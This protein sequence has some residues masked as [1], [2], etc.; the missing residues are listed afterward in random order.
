M[1]NWFLITEGKE[2]GPVQPGRLR[3]LVA[4]G[5][6]RPNDL[7]RRDDMSKPCRADQIKGLFP[8]SAQSAM[9]AQLPEVR[10]ARQDATV[11]VQPESA[12]IDSM[13]SSS[14]TPRW[15]QILIGFWNTTA[16]ASR[17][18]ALQVK[19]TKLQSV[20]L[21]R[22]FA[23]LGRHVDEASASPANGDEFT[24][25]RTQI[26]DL[27]ARIEA[28]QTVAANPPAPQG[29][30][31][32][33]KGMAKATA[34]AAN[35]KKLELQLGGIH[36]DLGKAAYER[37]GEAAG[38]AGIM[39][40]IIK[41]SSRVKQIDDEQAKLESA[42]S[43]RLVTP[44]RLAIS[45]L[46]FVGLALCAG[47]GNMVGLKPNRAF[48]ADDSG[49]PNDGSCL[50]ADFLPFVPGAVKSYQNKVFD[51]PNGNVLLIEDLKE[52]YASDGLVK[53]EKT[54][55]DPNVPP[56]TTHRQYHVRKAE[57]FVGTSDENR[58]VK[59]GAKPAETWGDGKTP[60]KGESAGTYTL[61]GFE[62][63]KST[64]VG[65][66]TAD[67]LRAI[68]QHQYQVTDQRGDSTLI[69]TETVLEVHGGVQ[70]RSVYFHC[71]GGSMDGKKFL[72]QQKRFI[73]SSI[74]TAKVPDR[75]RPKENL[76][77]RNHFVTFHLPVTIKCENPAF[78]VSLL[79]QVDNDQGNK[80][81]TFNTAAFSPTGRHLAIGGRDSSGCGAIELV[82]TATGTLDACVWNA[83]ARGFHMGGV[84][85]LA[86]SPDGRFLA[87]GGR[88]GRVKVFSV[89][90]LLEIAK[91]T[92]RL[93]GFSDEP[94]KEPPRGLVVFESEVSKY[95][96]NTLYEDLHLAFSV[97]G[98]LLFAG[99]GQD[100]APPL[101]GFL[102]S[103]RSATGEVV[104]SKAVKGNVKGLAV[105]PDNLLVGGGPFRIWSATT[106]DPLTRPI[107]NNIKGAF[108]VGSANG[109]RLAAK[110]DIKN[111]NGERVDAKLVVMKSNGLTA[112][113]VIEP[114]GGPNALNHFT[115]SPDG[116]LVAT[117]GK[118]W[119][120]QIW[121]ALSAEKLADITCERGLHKFL[122]F[123]P[124]GKKLV[125]GG[126]DEWVLLF[127]IDSSVDLSA[128][129]S[130]KVGHP[131][132]NIPAKVPEPS[133]RHSPEK[134]TDTPKPSTKKSAA[135]SLS[136]RLK[137]T[138]WIN[139]NGVSF[140]WDENGT[141]IHGQVRRPYEVVD[142]DRIRIAFGKDHTD[143]LVFDKD[144]NQF[145]QFSSKEPN[146]RPLFKGK[147]AE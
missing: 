111:N 127:D 76:F 65:G 95:D 21:P 67:V 56:I 3:E 118:G 52:T 25:I 31:D 133:E 51:F 106:G 107:P 61:V 97:D 75:E 66:K 55:T 134:A 132:A 40:P 47:L 81:L 42:S 68:I 124:D 36:A 33:A 35:R 113:S 80:L 115:I 147:R 77:V 114:K 41:G 109:Q 43:G 144:L 71:F 22:A 44:R 9:P 12:S 99:A 110:T 119:N 78:K 145:E 98:S 70:S 32:K 58:L 54:I 39:V 130:N 121:N 86:F 59:L 91:P 102:T 17:L 143:T 85:G 8:N 23:A 100:S 63:A 142:D 5:Q 140:V 48:H 84:I 116:R 90:K 129:N 10:P 1:A 146:K 96:P 7:V 112:S 126:Y 49:F 69:I 4:N 57:G 53:E 108:V 37:L 20:T 131:L 73:A 104:F 34:D 101:F 137:G 2:N 87:T 83:D 45:A 122:A 16:D 92:I 89:E 125:A 64:I 29:V 74:P 94:G 79:G 103:W 62:T 38:P 15:K 11:S 28:T 60:N 46:A 117:T 18:T 13:P 123:S 82:N 138:K 72:T 141:L 120:I 105:L 27:K 93:E 14:A 136:E 30:L 88:S 139:T 19:K 26:R 50:T 24:A 6:L 128:Q 135:K